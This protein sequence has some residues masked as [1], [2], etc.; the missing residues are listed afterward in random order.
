MFTWFGVH[1]RQHCWEAQL[2]EDVHRV[3]IRNSRLGNIEKVL[4]H[5]S[6]HDDANGEHGGQAAV[7]GDEFPLVQSLM[8]VQIVGCVHEDRRL[9]E[10]FYR[11]GIDDQK[12]VLI[13]N[14]FTCCVQ[15]SARN[16]AGYHQACWSSHKMLFNREEYREEDYDDKNYHGEWDPVEPDVYLIR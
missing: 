4:N 9:E 10:V 13:V 5:E 6:A 12:T 8:A 7:Y 14:N 15:D 16:E 11:R 3:L 1:G 2:L